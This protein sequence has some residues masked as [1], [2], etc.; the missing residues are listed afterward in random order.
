[1]VNVYVNEIL[2]YLKHVEVSPSH[3]HTF[4]SYSSSLPSLLTDSPKVETSFNEACHFHFSK[5]L[6]SAREIEVA[7]LFGYMKRFRLD[8]PVKE[9]ASHKP[10]FWLDM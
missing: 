7:R 2:D 1:M 9:D 10:G 4:R 5:P 8:D 3:Y 6:I